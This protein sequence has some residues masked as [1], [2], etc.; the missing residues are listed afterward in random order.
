MGNTNRR[1][2][3]RDKV[4][5][6]TGKLCSLFSLSLTLI[7]PA[8]LLSLLLF[9]PDKAGLAG[10][11]ISQDSLVSDLIGE[12]Q[13]SR[14]VQMSLASCGFREFEIRSPPHVTSALPTEPSFKYLQFVIII[15]PSE[16]SLYESMPCKIRIC[17][18]ISNLFSGFFL[19]FMQEVCIF[20]I[21][22]IWIFLFN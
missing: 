8:P 11:W 13:D 15:A 18:S 3:C 12:A 6:K 4:V 21:L 20:Q 22:Y 1:M 17:S 16:L 7:S 2:K 10:P 19:F 14:C 9:A 5:W